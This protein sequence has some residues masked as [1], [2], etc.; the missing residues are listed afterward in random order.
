[1]LTERDPSLGVQ[2]QRLHRR[3]Q[4]GLLG[5]LGRP[6]FQLAQLLLG[7]LSSHPPALVANGCMT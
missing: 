4:D 7:A 5:E 3:L 1:M 2:L 6:R